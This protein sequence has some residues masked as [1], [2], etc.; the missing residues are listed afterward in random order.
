MCKTSIDKMMYTLILY[1][2]TLYKVK[3]AYIGT[4]PRQADVR[5]NI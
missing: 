4:Y 1:V 2:F 3:V 5:D